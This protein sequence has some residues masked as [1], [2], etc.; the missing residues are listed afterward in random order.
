M[1]SVIGFKL[2]LNHCNKASFKGPKEKL[3]IIC[4][5]GDSRHLKST[6]WPPRP[7]NSRVLY[8]V[9]DCLPY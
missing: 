2:L 4:E 9:R 5:I 1:R 8:H 3:Q 6:G 7:A